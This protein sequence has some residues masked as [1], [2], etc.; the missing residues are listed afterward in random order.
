[1]KPAYAIS[2]GNGAKA[3]GVTGWLHDRMSLC[4]VSPGILLHI[5]HASGWSEYRVLTDTF[6]PENGCPQAALTTV[7]LQVPI[8]LL[9][10]FF[11]SINLSNHL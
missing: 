11:M 8:L 5:L 6:G 7:Q 2:Y 4:R 9:A 10:V 1:M 3:G